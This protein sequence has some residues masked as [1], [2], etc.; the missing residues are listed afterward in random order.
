MMERKRNGGKVKGNERLMRRETGKKSREG[1]G[2]PE[3]G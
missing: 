2:E 3:R 1:V